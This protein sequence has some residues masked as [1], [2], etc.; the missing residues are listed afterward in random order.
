MSRTIQMTVAIGVAAAA[1]AS[2]ALAQL[3]PNRGHERWNSMPFWTDECTY[4]QVFAAAQFGT[5]PIEIHSVA[6]APS[7][8][9]NGEEYTLDQVR[10]R[11]GYSD[12]QPGQLSPDLSANPRG[13]MSE[14]F[15]KLNCA[16]T[17]DYGGG[18][19]FSLS[20]AFTTPFCYDPANGNLLVEI[21]TVNTTLIAISTSSCSGMPDASRAWNSFTFGNN[22]DTTAT[23]MMFVTTS[24]GGPMLTLDGRCPGEINVAWS[25]ATPNQ[26]MGILYA[27]NA[28]RFVVPGGPCAGTELGLGANQIQLVS[29]VNTGEGSGSINGHAGAGACGGYIQLVL[30]NGAPCATSNVV[31]LP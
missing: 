5:A 13:P 31:Q 28:G 17:L 11:L 16:G 6:F 20:F 26:S 10:I 15:N 25:G 18:D 9:H 22:A 23:R 19:Y 14:V 12:K 2:P 21:R 3:Y 29:T 24:C 27:R 1:L 8:T 7:P 30:A 4:Q